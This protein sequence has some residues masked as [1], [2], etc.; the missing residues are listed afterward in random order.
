M[1]P[2]RP[3]GLQVAGE[4][5]QHGP[6]LQVAGARSQH[7][8]VQRMG[9]PQDQP[10]AVELDG[11][12]LCRLERGER[13][14]V[15]NARQLGWAARF[16][17][18]DV[19]EGGTQPF[20][21]LPEATTHDVDQTRR[22]QRQLAERRRRAGVAGQGT[23]VDRGSEQL[24]DE[25]RVAAG[26]VPEALLAACVESPAGDGL[27]HSFRI[28]AAERADLEP[29]ELTALPQV[30]QLRRRD[31]AGA[32]GGDHLRLAGCDHLVHQ[33]RRRV[34]EQVDVV[35][36][37]QHRRAVGTFEDSLPDLGEHRGEKALAGAELRHE[38]AEGQLAG[39]AGGSGTHHRPPVG[40]E[41]MGDGLRQ[42]ALAHS[43]GSHQVDARP[44]PER[45][46]CSG[47]LGLAPDRLALPAHTE[48]SMPPTCPLTRHSP[49]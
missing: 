35:D 49:E 30:E 26:D 8:A 46:N 36:A 47:H 11:H 24:V 4:R 29:G 21:Q 18:G 10:I 5:R 27:G 45:G 20:V 31:A 12:Q 33:D 16:G 28:G 37:D 2:A 25:Q 42:A 7:L 48:L 34:V 23:L 15:G 40:L 19:Q 38:R 17:E 3:S 14:G 9:E 41:R 43:R 32:Q 13:V 1:S 22:M 44:G 39:A 6:T